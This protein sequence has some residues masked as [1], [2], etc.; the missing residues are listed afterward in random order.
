MAADVAVF[1]F[2]VGFTF[3]ESSLAAG[4]AVFDEHGSLGDSGATESTVK[5]ISGSPKI[6]GLSILNGP[7]NIFLPNLT[8][9]LPSSKFTDNFERKSLLSAN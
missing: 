4:V 1:L 5:V 2:R 7:A 8:L 3:D 9:Q 6:D